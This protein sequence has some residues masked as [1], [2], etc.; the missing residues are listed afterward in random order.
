MK[1]GAGK[2]TIAFLWD[3]SFLWGIMA[4]K[5]LREA[6]LP[7]RLIRAADIETGA[8][9]G[10]SALVVPGGWASNK[11]KVLGEPGISGIR[12]FVKEGGTY[13][14]FCGGAG[15]ATRDGIG[16]LDA[17]RKPTSRRVPSFSGRIRLVLR[18]D[19]LW[20]GIDDPVF[21]A[22][23]P[24]Q[25]IVG[26]GVS[27]LARYGEALA[28]AF[29][30]DLNVGDAL[31]AGGWEE[32]EEYYGINLDPGRMLNEPS[33]IRGTYGR[34]TVLLSLVHFDS[35]GD[36]N[37]KVVLGNLWNSLGERGNL[38]TAQDAVSRV[39][40][41]RPTP[42]VTARP[43]LV[44][45]VNDLK[46][47][48][49]GII[50]L[51]VRN[52]LWFRQDPFLLHWRRG[53]RGLEYCTLKVMMDELAELITG[54]ETVPPFGVTLTTESELEK[55]SASTEA[56]LADIRKL[57]VP[58]LEEAR[59]LLLRERRAMLREKL[60]FQH[61]VDP[62]ISAARK[63]LFSTSKSH[64]GLFK[65]VIDHMDSLLWSLLA[66]RHPTGLA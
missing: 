43:A 31:A 35:P 51:G 27:V 36:S 52:F 45:E 2:S 33:V 56:H 59:L 54:P 55:R 3:E 41:A 21:R 16:L 23:W 44:H 8:L 66:Y 14:G 62:Q 60:T 10:C 19:P 18:H 11:I 5:A 17:R 12:Q 9:L 1:K 6:G 63:R 34:G 49:D 13:I 39:V 65:Q 26:E 46:Q 58:F 29:S 40:D 50:D 30:S 64:G 38:K 28:D 22:R 57:L 47:K 15:L 25:L 48:V 32:L 61:S 4:Y 24:S 7:F 53:V 37:G 20:K 42:L